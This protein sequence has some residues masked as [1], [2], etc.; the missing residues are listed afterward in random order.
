MPNIFESALTRYLTEAQL[1]LIQRERICI[2]GAG[3]LGSNVAAVLVRTGFK[4]L[5]VLDRD[6]VEASNLNRQDYTLADVGRPKVEALR[7]RL[8]GINPSALIVTHQA[9]WTL[10]SSGSFFVGPRI[11]VEAFDQAETKSA[12]VNWAAGCAEFVVS[13]N[14]M[15]GLTGASTAPPP[16]SARFGAAPAG[17]TGASTAAG[18][19]GTGT[20]ATSVRQVGNV[21]IVGDGA[22]S[23]ETGQPPLAPRVLQCAAR[24]A[25][26]VLALT[27]G[28]DII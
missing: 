10:A 21:Y 8:L 13:G 22:T 24:M 19:A 27:L 15:A 20:T 7:E 11:V 4:H 23:T 5:E 2:A 25:E 1:R 28:L 17:L 6:A 26:I 3:G 16:R 14:G 18:L 9:E 12:F